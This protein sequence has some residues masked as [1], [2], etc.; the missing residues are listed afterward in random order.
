MTNPPVPQLD[1][2][3]GGFSVPLKKW[4]YDPKEEAAMARRSPK[5]RVLQDEAMYCTL[6]E[7]T[8]DGNLMLV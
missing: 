3:C 8:M 2:L 6:L 4:T 7:A 5:S 1:L